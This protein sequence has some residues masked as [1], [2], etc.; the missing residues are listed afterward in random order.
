[1]RL[2]ELIV[3]ANHRAVAG[4]ASS[5]LHPVAPLP[6]RALLQPFQGCWCAGA[7]PRVARSS[8]PWADR[9]ES[10]Q[11]SSRD[12]N[13]QTEAATVEKRRLKWRGEF[14]PP[15]VGCYKVQ[16]THFEMR[17]KQT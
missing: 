1:M 9:F 8:Q 6:S 11:D 17:V 13:L 14:E 3:D 2:F 5:G 15:H 10:L 16:A 7:R 4:D 12:L